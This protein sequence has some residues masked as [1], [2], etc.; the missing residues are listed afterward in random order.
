LSDI[1][2]LSNNLVRHYQILDGFKMPSVLKNRKIV[3]DS[4]PDYGCTIVKKFARKYNKG[5]TQVIP[6]FYPGCNI[7]LKLHFD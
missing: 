1:Q 6:P 3:A 4:G 2:L 5:E 7:R